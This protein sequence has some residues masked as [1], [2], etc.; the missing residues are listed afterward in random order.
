MAFAKT[1]LVHSDSLKTV[2]DAEFEAFQQLFKEQVLRNLAL[3]SPGVLPEA[4]HVQQ[5][6]RRPTRNIFADFTR[7][8]NATSSTREIVNTFG[9][10][11]FEQQLQDGDP[12]RRKFHLQAKVR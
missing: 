6:H 8:P 12:A 5:Q 3:T 4:L 2:S 10:E 9:I 11:V 1:T 7:A